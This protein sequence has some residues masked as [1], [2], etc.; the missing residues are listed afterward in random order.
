MRITRK[1]LKRL[2][3]TYL[4]EGNVTVELAT[5]INN[6]ISKSELSEEVKL[7]LQNLI[8]SIE[9]AKG[10]NIIDFLSNN[11]IVNFLKSQG[12]ATFL[13]SA[14]NI[15]TSFIFVS[16]LF[17]SLPAM[18]DKSINALNTVPGTLRNFKKIKGEPVD[19]S[20]LA[21]NPG[22][23][24][25]AEIIKSFGIK[26]ISKK[27]MIDFLAIGIGLENGKNPV[28]KLYQDDIITEDFYKT[29]LSRYR[30]LREE[31]S[32]D[33]IKKEILE[34]ISKA[35]DDPKEDIELSLKNL[36]SVASKVLI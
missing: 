1:N 26:T 22:N 2:I 10:K 36:I 32:I 21:D 4:F 31:K 27:D 7:G 18:I 8:S 12:V 25:Y 17:T 9:I 33:N 24:V 30:E 14:G 3:E 5:E 11:S 29:V 15:F 6:K 34:S 13:I 35:L 28:E 23:D 19:L 20:M 16:G